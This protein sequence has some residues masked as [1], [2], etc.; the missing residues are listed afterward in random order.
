MELFQLLQILPEI[1]NSKYMHRKQEKKIDN[2]QKRVIHG[3]WIILQSVCKAKD[4][5]QRVEEANFPLLT[6]CLPAKQRQ[7]PFWGGGYINA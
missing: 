1:W 7:V 6:W 3:Q 5:C 4:L 2:R